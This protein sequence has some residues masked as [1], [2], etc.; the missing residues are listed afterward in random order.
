M[1][2]GLG[3]VVIDMKIDDLVIIVK[4]IN[5]G[6]EGYV[7]ILSLNKKVIVYFG[8]KVGIELKGDWVDK[9]YKNKSGDFEYMY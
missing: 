2:D 8:E 6:K 3:V 9:F 5:I 1:E 7:F 4:G